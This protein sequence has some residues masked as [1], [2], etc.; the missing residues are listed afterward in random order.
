MLELTSALIVTKRNKFPR[1]E[2]VNKIFIY[3]SVD[4]KLIVNVDFN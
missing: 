1:M 2:L 3:L 4:L